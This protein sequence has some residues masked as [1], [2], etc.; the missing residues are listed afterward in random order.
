MKRVNAIVEIQK[1]SKY[2]YEMDIDSGVLFLDRVI[3]LPYPFSYGYFPG[4]LSEDQDPLDLFLISNE[5]ITQGAL[6]QVKIV[7]AFKC[8]DGQL[9]QDDKLVCYLDG[10]PSDDM[11]RYHDYNKI[12]EFLRNYKT[13]FEVIEFVDQSEAIKIYENSVKAFY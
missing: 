6:C 3:Q 9:T 13:N 11:C 4:T 10:E 8:R 12:D 7:G 5:P 2:K 1:N